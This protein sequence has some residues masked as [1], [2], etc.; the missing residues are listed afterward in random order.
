MRRMFRTDTI[1]ARL[2]GAFFLV[3][4]VPLAVVGFLVY[5]AGEATLRDEL[6]QRLGAVTQLRMQ[7]IHAWLEERQRDVKRP[8]SI[9]AFRRRVAEVLGNPRAPAAVREELREILEQTRISG[10]FT[11]LFLLDV[12]EGTVLMSTDPTQEGKLKR[13]RPYFREGRERPYV[14]HIYYSIALGRAV[15]TFSAPVKDLDNRSIAI[16]VGRADLRYLDVL[17]AERAG[18][19][20]TGQTFLVNRFNYFVSASLGSGRDGWRPVFSDGVQRAL[21]GESG[22]AV[23]GNH[24]GEQVVGAY[25]PIPQIGVALIAEMNAAEAFGPI[26]RFRIGIVLLL[27]LVC[28]AAGLIGVRL[29]WGM[30]RPIRALA[31]A[32]AA[33][34]H[35]HL[36]Q[37]VAVAGPREVTALAGA[38]NAM[39]R[40]L[41]RSRDE[42]MAYST[43]LEAKVVERTR[44]VT[45][46]LEVTQTLGSTLDLPE[47]LRRAARSLA[48]VLSADTGLA[49]ILNEDRTAL[50]WI[51]GYH[52]PVALRETSYQGPVL[53]AEHSVVAHACETGEIAFTED[54]EGDASATGSW[55]A[56]WGFR[57][58][59][60]VPVFCA[61]RLVG[62]LF[63]GWR[64]PRAS[65]T[66]DERDL[67][68]GIGR[69]AGIAVQNSALFSDSE[70]RRRAA[71]TLAELETVLARSLD[72]GVVAEGIVRGTRTL[73]ASRFSTVYRLDPRTG[74]LVALAGDGGGHGEAAAVL[75]AGAG[76]CA[77]AI[78]HREAVVSPDI[79]ADPRVYLPPRLR[80]RVEQG[81]Y[82]AMLAAPLRVGERVIGALCLGDDRGRVFSREE[83]RLLG[84]FAAQAALALENARLYDETRARAARMTRLSEL[85]RVIT[86]TLELRAVLDRIAGSA[87]ELLDG[88]LARLW[89]ADDAAG[90]V[91]LMASQD[92]TGG[93]S[94][95]AITEL[96]LGVGVVGHVMTTRRPDS[97]P[98]LGTGPLEASDDWLRAAGYTSRL[99][100]PLI[101]GDQAVGALSILTKATREFAQEEQEILELFASEAATAVENARLYAESESRRREA[102]ALAGA[103]RRM[104]T[105]LNLHELGRQLVE[106]VCEL[107][108]SHGSA[109]Y[110]VR[111]E[112][113]AIVA[114]AF[115]G[116]A[117]A[118]RPV[119]GI[120]P[121]GAGVVGRAIAGRQ[122]VATR[123][124][125]DDPEVFLPDELRAA[126]TTAGS[127]AVLAVPL[128][129]QDRVIGALTVS[130]NISRSFDARE[131]ALLQAFGDQAA[132]ALENARL[133]ADVEAQAAVLAKQN[134]ELNAFTYSVSHDLKSPLVTIQAM[135]GLLQEDYGDRLDE[136]GLRVLSRITANTTHMASLIGDLLALSRIGREAR[137]AE[138]VLARDVVHAV[139]DGLSD[140]IQ[141][142]GVAVEVNADVTVWAVRVQLEQIFANL[143]GN[144]VKYLGDTA[145]PRIEI[146]AEEG[147]R[148]VEFWVRDNGIGIDP[149]YHERIFEL[150]QRLRDVE[151]E[152]TGVGLAIVKKILDSAGGRIWVESV[153]GQGATFRFTW[154][155]NAV[156]RAA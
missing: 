73:L 65:L 13:D 2:L 54:A 84:T 100:V 41:A 59:L 15:L 19:G 72:G 71:E 9:R 107:F 113:G 55:L 97:T 51:A 17:M 128:V 156:A 27:V 92:R 35:G 4:I 66:Q 44:N 20:T 150:F 5:R 88:D 124:I 123:N 91:K 16:L 28:G 78:E 68:D 101:A 151:A 115:G 94:L 119:G 18:L 11:E 53:L 118:H 125:L 1:G 140:L 74:D 152:G 48:R 36:D 109:L 81:G 62:G 98:D 52:V 90:V 145:T 75:P 49:S 23:Y 102:E 69:Q 126:L 50:H 144:A 136:D 147:E 133:F 155:V 146:G 34:G 76:L 122:P 111:E 8:A 43:A 138:A 38:F 21:A 32:A 139:L 40:D 39:T 83:A 120:L 6:W 142:R 24:A 29:A 130:D 26:H 121:P 129:I 25:R 87:C 61:G 14:Q 63:A 85:G 108:K 106:A 135:C 77:V 110:R 60:F 37:Q 33:I 47:T 104:S 7:Q 116:R 131:T 67:I 99:V 45:A 137:P 149:A 141:A 105:N 64:S 30:T 31:D 127:R 86:S 58:A 154:P 132:L 103:A 80:Q 57:A 10:A 153:P 95:G 117:G 89:V 143:I 3:S 22:T 12:T 112:D 134:V 114:V 148:A 46:L 82:P 79:L 70:Q 42:L 96:P 56:G 93:T